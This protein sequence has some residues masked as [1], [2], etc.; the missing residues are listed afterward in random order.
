MAC[1]DFGEVMLHLCGRK[2]E[3]PNEIEETD[4]VATNASKI[5]PIDVK[6]RTIRPF[7]PLDQPVVHR[8]PSA[9]AGSART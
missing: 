6:C 5:S 7:A 1:E 3:Q 9:C 4:E 2:L 8:G